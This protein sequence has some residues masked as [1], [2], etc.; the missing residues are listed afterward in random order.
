MTVRE[1]IKEIEKF[2][3]DMPVEIICTFDLGFGIAGG[4]RI[5]VLDRGDH[6]ELFNDEC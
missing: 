4:S 6:V 1:L 2:P 5:E 3:P